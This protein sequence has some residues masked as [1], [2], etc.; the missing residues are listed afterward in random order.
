MRRAGPGVSCLAGGGGYILLLALV[1]LGLVS[2]VSIAML[3]SSVLE[4]RMTGNLLQRE[5]ALQLARG[6]AAVLSNTALPFAAMQQSGRVY[7]A[8]PDACNADLDQRVRELLDAAQPAAQRF[9]IHYEIRR[10]KPHVPGAVAPRLGETRVSDAGYDTFVP[11]EL[12]VS[13]SDPQDATLRADVVQGV[14]LRLAD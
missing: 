12:R 14:L 6:V 4:L 13:V 7:C 9:Q 1:F 2:A 11:F 8:A 5:E 10:I 3:R